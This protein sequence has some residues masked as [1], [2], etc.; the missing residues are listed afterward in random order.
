MKKPS[1]NRVGEINV[2]CAGCEVPV[3][4]PLEESAV[5]KV[6]MTGH[7]ARGGSG[8]TVISEK[9]LSHQSG[10]ITDTEAVMNYFKAKSPIM[11]GEKNRISL[12]HKEDK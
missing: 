1:N 2:R 10:N 5:Y 6:I 8:L 7:I 12:E 9:K 4:K 11:T 3:Y